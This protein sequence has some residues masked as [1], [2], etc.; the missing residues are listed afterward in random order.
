M[1]YQSTS[2]LSA[3]RQIYALSPSLRYNSYHFYVEVLNLTNLS[4]S[5]SNFFGNQ[6]GHSDCYLYELIFPPFSSAYQSQQLHIPINSV[7]L[8]SWSNTPLACYRYIMIGFIVS[9]E[10]YGSGPRTTSTYISTPYSCHFIVSSLCISN[11][12]CIS[13]V[14][15]FVEAY[16]T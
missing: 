1:K 10:I 9:F 14:A 11:G 13:R 2:S 5:F 6:N 4:V 12:N 15:E 16:T 8:P 7:F 3:L